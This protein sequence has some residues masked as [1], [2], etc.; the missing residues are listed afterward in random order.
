MSDDKQ[1][2]L[3]IRAQSILSEK[4]KKFDPNITA[5]DCVDDL[6]RIQ[7]VHEHSYISR[8]F[9][10]INGAYSDKTWNRHFGTFLEFRRQAGLELPR[11]AH[12][13]EK[14]I[15]KQASVD[16]Y[17]EYYQDEVLPYHMKYEKDHTGKLI[18]MM[19]FSDLHDKEM[20]KFCWGVFL[21]QAK[22]IQ[23]D[24]IIANGDIYDLYEFSRFNKDPRKCDA[25]GRM[26][27]VRDNVWKPLRAACPN[28]QID[29]IVGNH[30]YRLL[31]LFADSSPHLQVVLS[32]FV[33]LKMSDIFG[34]DEFKIN[35]ICKI[36][37]SFY[38]KTDIENELKKNYKVYFD[39]FVACHKPS[40]RF[41]MSGTN[42]HHHNGQLKTWTNVSKGEL[43]QC[44]WVQTPAIHA[45]D[46]DYI[47]G[48]GQGNMGFNIVNINTET[49]EVSQQVVMVHMD[50]ALVNG[51]YYQRKK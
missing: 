8:N 5:Q 42:G 36:D 13:L 48:V 50:W 22:L 40:S 2:K 9:Y 33:G 17:R 10:R 46:T 41:Q 14:Q 15:A 35:L 19:V 44:S 11:Q 26:H 24:I 34:L 3:S 31:R 43:T 20:W 23:P 7:S 45:P 29:M 47:E 4:A 16:H 39:C 25:A 1:P 30:E 27:F 21:D 18:T 37:F 6:R 28:A 12:L 51:K 49:K 38:S 32:D